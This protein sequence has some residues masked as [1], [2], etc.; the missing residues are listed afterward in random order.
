[1]PKVENLASTLQSHDKKVVLNA[2]QTLVKN[3][4]IDLVDN[5]V[6]L[7]TTRETDD[8]IRL[9]AIKA[10]GDLG[11]L[12]G[13]PSLLDLLTA[14]SDF[15]RLESVIALGKIKDPATVG[16]VVECLGD[17]SFNV[18]KVAIQALGHFANQ[19][20]ISPL[21][22]IA[23]DAEIKLELRELA[24]RSLGEIGLPESVQN[25]MRL[26]QDPDLNLQ[27]EAVEALGKTASETAIEPLINLI[28]NPGC[29]KRIRKFAK[30]ALSRLLEAEK[31][32]YLAIKEKIEAVL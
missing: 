18:R 13:V 19:S 23:L 1:M 26:L 5:L 17:I 4:S 9:A 6:H 25:L 22:K 27:K 29:D 31:S 28:A 11:D 24:I 8:E 30:D 20:A 14:R 2:I 3:H 12:S 16:S 32:R 21:S 10:L 7:I 15:L